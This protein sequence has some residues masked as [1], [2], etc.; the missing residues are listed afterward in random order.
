MRVV[1]VLSLSLSLL[2]S[3]SLSLAVSLSQSHALFLFSS[4][5]TEKK[6][7]IA[8]RQQRRQLKPL[9]SA[10]AAPYSREPITPK[11]HRQSKRKQ[12]SPFLLCQMT[13]PFHVLIFLTKLLD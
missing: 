3:L 10:F 2:L 4:S 11:F 13:K 5:P 1:Q 12:I 7:N 8:D 6:T 9:G